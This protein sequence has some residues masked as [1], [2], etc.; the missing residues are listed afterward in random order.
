EDGIR[1]R[2]VTGVQTCALPICGV[3]ELV[4][5]DINEQKAE[6][7][8]MD[9]NHGVP[10]A[11]TQTKVWKGNYADCGYADIVVITAGAPQKPGETRQIGRASCRDREDLMMSID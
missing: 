6:G 11:S 4:L 9:L 10:F 1:Y 2:N 5:V 8:A 7:E 3:E